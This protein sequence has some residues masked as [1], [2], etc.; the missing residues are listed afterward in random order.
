[1]H[2]R[3]EGTAAERGDTQPAYPQ[4][5]TMI[6]ESPFRLMSSAGDATYSARLGRNFHLAATNSQDERLGMLG[7]VRSQDLTDML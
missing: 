1:M 5:T 4:E 6:N 3:A 7:Y 2:D